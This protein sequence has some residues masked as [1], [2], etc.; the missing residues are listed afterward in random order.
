MKRAKRIPI[1][2]RLWNEF[3][4]ALRDYE[5]QFGKQPT[6]EEIELSR[7]DIKVWHRVG[8][9]FCGFREQ[10][11]CLLRRLEDAVIEAARNT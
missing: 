5:R 2:G 1:D 9:W 7:S 11:D 4:F 10:H 8:D 3:R 6:P